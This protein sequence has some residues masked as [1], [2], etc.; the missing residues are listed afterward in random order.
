VKS[1]NPPKGSFSRFFLTND[2]LGFKMKI[3]K[4]PGI[5]PSVTWGRIS[6][7]IS[8]SRGSKYN[9]SI[10]RTKICLSCTFKSHIYENENICDSKLEILIISSIHFIKVFDH[11][12]NQARKN[13]DVLAVLDIKI[14]CSVLR[15]PTS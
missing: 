4:F 5:E 9:Y 12:S 10:F 2:N 11:R 14:L 15:T 13:V 6:G 3:L 7:D 8:E 1:W